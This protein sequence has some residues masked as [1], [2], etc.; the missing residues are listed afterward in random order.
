MPSNPLDGLRNASIQADAPAQQMTDLR[1][2]HPWIAKAGDFLTGGAT[3]PESQMGPVDV[4]GAA[5]PFL[6]GLSGMMGGAAM[7]GLEAGVDTRLPNLGRS[8]GPEA[9]AM[10]GP[11]KSIMSHM[12]NERLRDLG[13]PS[14]V[15][16]T[17]EGRQ[18]EIARRQ[19]SGQAIPE[20][21]S[22]ADESRAAKAVAPTMDLMGNQK[23]LNWMHQEFDANNPIL[24]KMRAQFSGNRNVK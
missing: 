18:M 19:A 3:N 14:D 22:E 17:L 9:D 5:I 24:N 12:Q 7:R 15:P 6:P 20:W 8:F 1:K 21:L 4:A 16:N 10:M 2:A 11:R 13:G 23:G